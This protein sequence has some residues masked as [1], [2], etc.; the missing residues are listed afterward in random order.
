MSKSNRWYIIKYNTIG[1]MY[2]KLR[3]ENMELPAP[4][5]TERLQRQSWLPCPQGETAAAGA[6]ADYHMD[7][8][9]GEKKKIRITKKDP[10]DEITLF[11]EEGRGVRRKLSITVKL[12][13]AVF[14]LFVLS[15]VLIVPY[16]DMQFTPAWIFYNIQQRFQQFYLF[17][18]GGEE[19]FGI[20][21]YKY[22]A[23]VVVGAGLAAC[24]AIFQGGFKNV[25]AGPSTMGVMSGG[26]LGTLIYLLLFTA[27]EYSSTYTE[28]DLDRYESMSLFELYGQQLF[29][30]LGCAA[31]VIMVLT[32]AT[33]AGR[34]KLSTSAMVLSG[35]VFSAFTQNISGVIQYYMIVKDPSDPRIEAVRD[36]MMGTF[37]RI[38]G[39]RTLL[40]LIIPI[41]ICLAALLS[42]RS[43]L[44]M[45]SISDED[46]LTMGID[47][48]K[49][50]YI[51]VA[52]GTVITAVVVAFCGHIGFLGF[53]VPLISRRMVGNDM[54][55]LLPV[56]M[57]MGSLLLILIFDAAYIAGLTDYM[58]MFTSA[59]GSIV[60]VIVLVR[61][62]GGVKR[63]A[64]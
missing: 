54:K 40:L 36:L 7:R 45:L 17:L 51:V 12:A 24:G 52:F 42:L 37:N 49:W 41:I 23:I 5:E 55:N 58:G 18:F 13:T 43:R 30:L 33:I 61:G 59:I 8:Y 14:F 62:R 57:L 44:N 35:T 9:G 48:K 3:S 22:I 1:S 34:G 32:I 29:T 11:R 2:N 46:A 39:L 4:E 63:A 38:T 56:S 19:T 47:S 60:M 28:A 53:M 21:V 10:A 20:L 25:L 50:R 26:S 16:R 6:E 64:K 27:V 31:G 15:L